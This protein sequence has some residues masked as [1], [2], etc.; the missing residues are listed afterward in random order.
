MHETI[1][2]YIMKNGLPKGMEHNYKM[3]GLSI[4]EFININRLT[5]YHKIIA[6]Q[7]KD[8]Q[9]AETVEQWKH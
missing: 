7:N 8:Q 2:Q 9:E 4:Q 6:E 5:I 3:S 1:E